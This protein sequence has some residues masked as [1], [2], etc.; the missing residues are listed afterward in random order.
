MTIKKELIDI[1]NKAH[2]QAWQRFKS[3]KANAST[4][5]LD[6]KKAASWNSPGEPALAYYSLESVTINQI[7]N[8]I[9]TEATKNG[10]TLPIKGTPLITQQFIHQKPK[11]LYKP[12]INS[13]EPTEIELGDLLFIRHHFTFA[14]PNPEGRA[15]ILQ[16]KANTKPTTGAL[17][18]GD[19][20]Q[21]VLYNDWAKKFKFK[22][23]EYPDPKSGGEWDFST[24]T[25]EPKNETG[26]YG[27]VYSGER[28]NMPTKLFPDECVWGIGRPDEAKKTLFRKPYITTNTLSLA[29]AF[30]KFIDCKYGRKWETN[31]SD[32]NDHWSEFINLV[33]SNHS[34]Q[35]II[36]KLA[37]I[38]INQPR[39]KQI[40]TLATLVPGLADCI[41]K[42]SQRKFEGILN[43]PAV[44]WMKSIGWDVDG[45]GLP[46][47]SSNDNANRNNFNGRINFIY[48]A[49]FG[50][51]P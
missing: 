48:I 29:D 14:N 18:R 28:G 35:S 27:V 36:P 19:A 41:L 22:N 46:P 20:K 50:P 42:T 51:S 44:E 6:P 34:F 32:P 45:N 3:V 49:T 17:S 30:D 8:A 13:K 43:S 7:K 12:R 1:F 10:Y 9:H 37:R 24:G 15:F 25:M 2:D 33:L 31:P 11:I 38:Q 21:F 5:G 26:I 47:I 4:F 39:H 40:L 16:A 23:G